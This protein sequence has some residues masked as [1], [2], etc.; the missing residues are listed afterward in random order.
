M[1]IVIVSKPC[2]VCG[3]TNRGPGGKCRDCGRLQEEKKR[4]LARIKPREKYVGPCKKCGSTDLRTDGK[5]RPCAVEYS[6]EYYKNNKKKFKDA[7]RKWRSD[8]KDKAKIIR[9]RW[10]S[11]NKDRQL[12]LEK[13]WREK[14]KEKISDNR[15]RWREKN[16]NRSRIFCI[17][18]RRKMA[19]GRLSKN[20]VE[21]L[22]KKQKGKCACCFTP[23][24]DDFHLD[25]IM[26]IKLGGE[27]IDSNIQLLHSAC[28]VRK[29]AKHPV[30]YMQ[31]LGFLI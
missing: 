31:E 14:N 21:I 22:M 18:R 26:P 7:S 11:N 17:N 20:I 16:A 6:K 1:D 2:R 28:N 12:M 9:D 3:S 5:C 15:K 19:G 23:L 29:N 8:N 4:R 24:N 10:L 30:D 25:H 27:N 13:K